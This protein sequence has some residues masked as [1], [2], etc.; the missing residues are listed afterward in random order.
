MRKVGNAESGHLAFQSAEESH[1]KYKLFKKYYIIK[2]I[3]LLSLNIFM[4][5][6]LLSYLSTFSSENIWLRHFI[7]IGYYN[8]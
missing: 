8:C 6:F 1:Y 3:L 7:R 4:S 2:N 5:T